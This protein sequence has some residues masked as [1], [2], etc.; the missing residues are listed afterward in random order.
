MSLPTSDEVTSDRLTETAPLPRSVAARLAASHY[1][2]ESAGARGIVGAA[3]DGHGGAGAVLSLARDDSASPNG[4]TLGH[5]AKEGAWRGTL[6]GS[7]RSITEGSSALTGRIEDDGGYQISPSPFRTS[8]VEI[9]ALFQGTGTRAS[10]DESVRADM[11]DFDAIAEGLL[12]LILAALAV[13]EDALDV[14]GEV[15]FDD[16]GDVL[17]GSHRQD[18]GVSQGAVASDTLYGSAFSPPTAGTAADTLH[19][20]SGPSPGS[21][22]IVLDSPPSPAMR[23]SSK[24]VSQGSSSRN[25]GLGPGMLPNTPPSAQAMR[26]PFDTPVAS[27]HRNESKADNNDAS[28]HQKDDAIQSSGNPDP[29]MRST[30]TKTSGTRRGG[31]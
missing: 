31:S 27:Q 9:E 6:R 20:R 17:G 23:R 29:S 7:P 5:S 11:H 15:E 2:L 16:H 4:G 26:Q 21:R 10:L 25:T 13:P 14:G 30:H 18:W 12:E 24:E 22:G 3:G 28:R 8:P 1:S 19:A